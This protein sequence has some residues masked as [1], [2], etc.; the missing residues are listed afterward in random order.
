MLRS[1]PEKPWFQLIL[2]LFEI[3]LMGAASFVILERCNMGG[4]WAALNWLWNKP[5]LFLLDFALG[6]VFYGLIRCFFRKPLIPA[7]VFVLLTAFLSSVNYYKMILRGDPLIPMDIYNLGVAAEMAPNMN[8]TLNS[9]IVMNLLFLTACLA[10]IWAYQR[11]LY[12]PLTER[13]GRRWLGAAACLALCLLFFHH[14]LDMGTL[15]AQGAVDVRYNQFTNYRTNGFLVSTMMNLTHIDVEE[16]EGYG[17]EAVRQAAAEINAWQ[18]PGALGSPGEMPHI[19]AIQMEAYGDPR[20]LSADIV[21]ETDPFSPL[22]PYQDE[23]RSFRT[24]TSIVGGGTANSEYEFLTGF[25]MIFCPPGVTPFLT[26]VNKDRPSLARDLTS[27]GYR[28]FALHPNTGSFYG[29]DMV[30]PNLGFQ[31]FYTIEDFDNPAYQGYY[32][33]DEAF[34]DKLIEIFDQKRKGEEGPIFAFGVSIQNHGPYNYPECARE[35]PFRAADLSLNEEQVMEISTY[36]AHMYDANVMLAE[37]MDYLSGLDEPVLLLVYGDHQASWTWANAFEQTPELVMEKYLTDSF[38]WANYPIEE[39]DTPLISASGLAPWL[40]RYADLPM[41]T[42][43]RGV[44]KQFE[45]KMAYNLAVTVDL[46]GQVSF[47]DKEALEPLKL[48]PYDRMFG[49]DYIDQERN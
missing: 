26:Y 35:Y 28:N 24:L 18:P 36:A 14:F 19:I 34:K 31:E 46:A 42:Y 1:W 5:R 17:P 32:V 13:R 12:R 23:L 25:N 43:F 48:L 37:L 9:V 8:I 20:R 40:L 41:N 3:L 33:T 6:A 30:Y 2:R 29:R 4:L 27:L 38:F 39:P 45:D 10:V 21:F 22:E 44:Q 47:S 7:C 11:W 49:K 16:P 15:K